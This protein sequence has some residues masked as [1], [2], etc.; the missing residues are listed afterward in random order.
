MELDLCSQLLVQ[1]YQRE[2]AYTHLKA[3]Q[4]LVEFYGSERE[5][6][7]SLIL[8]I[9]ESARMEFVALREH[10]EE[11]GGLRTLE[12]WGFDSKYVLSDFD[13]IPV[14]EYPPFAKALNGETV[15]APSMDTPEFEPL[16]QREELS[17]VKSFVAMP[18]RVGTEIFGVLSV[19]SS[20][21]YAYNTLERSAFEGL[22]NAAGLAI[23]YHRANHEVTSQ[24]REF[25]EISTALTAVEVAQASRHEAIVKA[26]NAA[27][28]ISG[29]KK[30]LKAERVSVAVQRLDGLKQDIKEIVE[31]VN[32]IKLALTPE[33]SELTEVS[34]KALWREAR[35]AT[36]GKLT[37]VHIE[38]SGSDRTVLV[39]PDRIR[40]VFINLFLNSADAFASTSTK[41]QRRIVVRIDKPDHENQ[42]TKFTYRDNAG[43]LQSHLL[44]TAGSADQADDIPVERLVFKKGVSS[45]ETGTGYGLW[46]AD[47]FM[48]QHAG[49]IAVV[50]RRAGMMF[51][52]ELPQPG[53]VEISGGTLKRT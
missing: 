19:A 47:R 22:A 44:H 26:G 17:E 14:A 10:D 31:A 21:E 25:T 2:F 46:L 5:L 4:T 23:R 29:I 3:S 51:E 35:S 16:S 24:V 52:L 42:P 11:V 27:T 50:E 9:A 12:T 45:K 49:S 34:L 8:Q 7:E 30:A 6:F 39:Y 43:G 1:I 33:A 18:I 41:N 36:A 28:A 13:F 20:C 53:S 37:K 40:Q 32:K 15:I 48:Q 38:I